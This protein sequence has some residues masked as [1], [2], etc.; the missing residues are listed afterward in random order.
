MTN[1][2][3][4]TNE[5]SDSDMETLS[6]YLS[7]QLSAADADALEQRLADDERFYDSAAPYIKLWRA[8]VWHEPR[9]RTMTPR[10]SVLL[11]AVAVVL[12]A[13]LPLTAFGTAV[14]E[15]RQL[16]QVAAGVSDPRLGTEIATGH[17]E[18]RV[19]TLPG[20]STV[21]LAP[22]SRLTYRRAASYWSGYV[23]TLK[24]TGVFTVTSADRPLYV[25]TTQGEATLFAGHY[26]V[27]CD[28]GCAAMQVT[29]VRGVALLTNGLPLDWH[30]VGAGG[31]GAVSYLRGTP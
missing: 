23:V 1:T 6:D 26:D 27:R 14:Q 24:G 5:L 31:H 22:M 12:M 17:D 21:Q 16:G 4:D 7:G 2:L 25:G 29:T 13:C 8:D 30:W 15:S 18:T 3:M 20:G 9:K 19:V 10:R 11:A 28:L